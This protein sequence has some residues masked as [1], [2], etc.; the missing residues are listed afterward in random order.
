MKV[1][2]FDYKTV[3]FIIFAKMRHRCAIY[4]P[5]EIYPSNISSLRPVEARRDGIEIIYMPLYTFFHITFNIFGLISNYS[6]SPDAGI[7]SYKFMS[8]QI[9]C[10]GPNSTEMYLLFGFN[11][12]IIIVISYIQ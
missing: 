11:I 1:A 12:L 5:D 3:Y 9:P 2:M 4:I 7:K 8:P 6:S 10:Y